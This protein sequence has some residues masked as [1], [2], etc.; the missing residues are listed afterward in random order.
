MDPQIDTFVTCCC[1]RPE[2]CGKDKRCLRRDEALERLLWPIARLRYRAEIAEERP[3]HA[4]LNRR[5][6]AR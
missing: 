2:V 1:T 5:A 6:P 3:S 4:R